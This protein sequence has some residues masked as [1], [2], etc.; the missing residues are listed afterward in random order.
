MYIQVAMLLG[1]AAGPRSSGTV[2]SRQ[3]RPFPNIM[4]LG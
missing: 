4:I 3:H 1:P 2:L